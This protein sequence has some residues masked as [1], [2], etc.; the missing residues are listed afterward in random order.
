MAAAKEN[1]QRRVYVLPTDLVE[2]IVAYQEDKALPSE[3]EAVRRFLDEAL[4]N[5]DSVADVINRFMARLENLRLASEIAKDVLVGHP[6]ITGLGFDSQSVTFH[7]SDGFHVTISDKGL[8]NIKDPDGDTLYWKTR[9]GTTFGT[10][11]I[12]EIPPR[13]PSAP[14]F[15]PGGMDDDIPF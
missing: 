9:E 12:S 4:K 11:F 6:L 1:T 10:G 14:A 8:V 5:R 2:R 13:P 7:S 15:E 3:V